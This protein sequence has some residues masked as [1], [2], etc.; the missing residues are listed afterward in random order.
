ML[1]TLLSNSSSEADRHEHAL[2]ERYHLFGQVGFGGFSQ[3]FRAWDRYMQCEVAV[4][5]LH[6]HLSVEQRYQ[7]MY[8]MQREAQVLA[9]LNHSAIPCLYEYNEHVPMLVLPFLDGFS[10]AQVLQR[11]RRGLPLANAIYVGQS[12][13]CILAYLHQRQ[14]VFCDLSANN[15]MLSSEGHLFLI[16]FGIAHWMGEA[17][18]RILRGLGTRGF[19]PPELYPD[20][21]HALSPAS[22]IYSLG[23][24]LHYACTGNDPTRM[25]SP[26]AFSS[27]S[28]RVPPSL[29]TLI[30]A[31][32]NPTPEK[33]PTLLEVQRTL[34]TQC[35]MY[36]Q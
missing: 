14:I 4:K 18:A 16:D 11:S 3:V 34:N 21:L 17:P 9:H 2:D 26:F 32:L 33:R 10:L 36:T 19:A 22:D 23:A 6:D 8:Q 29:S 35:R 20:A 1:N 31:M 27:P 28:D 7:G 24:L 13:C 5:L 15:V 12:L 25:P 30:L